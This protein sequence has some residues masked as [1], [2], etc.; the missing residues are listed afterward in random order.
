MIRSGL[1]AN[2]M[3]FKSNCLVINKAKQALFVTFSL[4]LYLSGLLSPD[5]LHSGKILLKSEQ[6]K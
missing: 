3:H 6:L 1:E 2:T 4:I 5:M